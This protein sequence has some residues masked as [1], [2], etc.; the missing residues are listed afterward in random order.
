[1]IEAVTFAR[2]RF[3]Q[4]TVATAALPK[5]AVA[6]VCGLR[7]VTFCRVSHPHL[8]PIAQSMFPGCIASYE[9]R[10]GFHGITVCGANETI[11]LS[12]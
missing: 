8:L 4:F 6:R 11:T 7:A 9:P 1:M 5:L 3:V 10:S 2:R 12:L